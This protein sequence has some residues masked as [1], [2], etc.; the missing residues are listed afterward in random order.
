M[1]TFVCCLLGVA[2]FGVSWE[3]EG[4][5]FTVAPG[6]PTLGDTLRFTYNGAEPGATL[7]GRDALRGEALL[8]MDTE[9]PVLLPIAMT[10]SGNTWS[11]SLPLNDAR[12]RLLLFRVVSDKD[13][14]NGNVPYTLVYDKEGKPLM[15]A[16]VQLASLLAGGGFMDFRLQ[17]DYLAAHAC[18]AREKEMYPEN[19]RIY[20]VEWNVMTREDR[21]EKTR[22][23][24]AAELNAFY[25]RFRGNGEAVAA[26]LPWFDQTG[27]K[28]RGEAIRDSAITAA[29]SGPVAEA[30][31]R[32]AIYTERDMAKRADLIEKF[33]AD[34]P[35]KAL[36]KDQ[37]LSVQFVALVN[38]KQLEKA[39]AIFDKM[40]AP[41]PNF[42]NNAAWQWI[43][44]G[45][46]LE[47]A[48]RIAGKGVEIALNPPAGARP[49]Y[50]S[51]E[52]WKEQTT[53]AAAMACDTYGLGLYKLGKY[54]D[55]EKAFQ[56]AYEKSK[57]GE[58]EIIERLLMA[59]VQN[60]KYDR[61]IEVGKT[62]IENGKTNDKLLEY[63][64][65]AYAKAKGSEKGFASFLAG[66]REVGAKKM[67]EEVIKSRV[68]KPA[69]PFALKDLS[70]RVVRLTDLKG[71][72]V[73]LDFWATWCGPCK[74][75]FPTLQ[76]VYSKYRK[77]G[78]VRILALD[79]WEHV[80]GRQRED[81]VKKFMAD[82]KY[83]FPVLYDEGVVDKYGVDGIPTKF[84]I[85]RKGNLAFKS[86]G[87][88]GADAM[89]GELTTQ[90]DLLLAE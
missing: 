87:F 82:N 48:V 50:L 25:E 30:S 33:L 60:G 54:A 11:G 53:Y 79:T 35:Q 76:K 15:G 83:T 72:V 67:K 57:G 44:K 63:C 90:I 12:A 1:R 65:T 13:Q 49:T 24:I 66:A 32:S 47:Q 68:N 61:A 31:R 88:N 28:A 86:V 2:L 43:E 29:P 17:R 40:S 42:L 77:N 84:I 34:F 7:G 16:N 4:Q 74:A 80:G 59:Y 51:D 6:R 45:E 75:S 9:L 85:D 21:D 14:D 23:K 38:S 19:W 8:M 52:A 18:L 55:A 39:L 3:A 78:G 62:A 41:D 22:A 69:I 36:A 20:P 70:G 64:R 5:V 89:L 46:N 10:R 81:L 71:K 37:L 56:Q 58:A 26:C 73:V 27:Q